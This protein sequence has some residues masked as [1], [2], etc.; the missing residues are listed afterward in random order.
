MT[1][2]WKNFKPKFKQIWDVDVTCTDSQ[3]HEQR[4]VRPCLIIKEFEKTGDMVLLI[5][6]TGI[7][8]SGR[9]PYTTK[10]ERNDVNELDNDSIALVFQMKS[11]S[12][13]RFKRKR[14]RITVS[15]YNDIEVHIR[16][17]F[18]LKV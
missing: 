5:P 11:V 10:I 18:R 3:G 4:G 2:R 6:F 8:D 14:G 15:K 16:N 1:E 9:F 12:K 7:L 17:I 13:S